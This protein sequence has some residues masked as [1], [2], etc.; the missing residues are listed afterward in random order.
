MLEFDLLEELNPNAELLEI[1]KSYTY[2]IKKGTIKHLLHTN[3]QVI[4]PTEY[5]ITYPTTITILEYKI[6]EISNKP[7][8]IKEH[9]QKYSLSE[10]TK[11][12]KKLKI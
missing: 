7:F 12:L 6:N 10:I 3:L 11:I 8:F 2:T 1:I 5:L 9:N 4:E